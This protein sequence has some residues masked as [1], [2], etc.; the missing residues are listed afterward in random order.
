MHVRGV[1][2]TALLF[3]VLFT[4]PSGATT[5]AER[6]MR[7][8]TAEAPSIVYGTVI[9]ATSHWTENHS[10]IVTDV[11]MAVSEVLKGEAVDEVV[12]TQPGGAVGKL[13]VDCDGAA[14]FLPGD[15]AIVFLDRNPRGQNHVVGLS[16][17]RFDVV[18]DIRGRKVVQ[19]VTGKEART[20]G[21]AS[22]WG[23]LAVPEGR[24]DI[25]VPLDEFLGGVRDLVRDLSN[26]GGR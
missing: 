9:S 22:A 14:A 2:L 5:V 3:T 13:R 18:E 15:E 11:R 25:P 23:R 19:G 1:V 24:R 7:D 16:Q 17:G 10:L 6:T 21:Q 26:E 8:M 12:F 20:L 4:V